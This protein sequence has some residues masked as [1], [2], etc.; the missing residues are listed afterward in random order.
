MD[1]PGG[2]GSDSDARNNDLF[3]TADTDQSAAHAPAGNVSHQA[4]IRPQ[5]F[6]GTPHFAF[7]RADGVL[8]QRTSATLQHAAPANRHVPDRCSGGAIQIT[9]VQQRL[10]AFPL[11]PLKAARKLRQ[12]VRC[13]SRPAQNG[14]L[15]QVQLGV[16][17]HPECTGEE[18]AARYPDTAAGRAVIQRALQGGGVVPDPVSLGAVRRIRHRQ[19]RLLLPGA[20]DLLP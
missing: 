10:V 1:I 11:N 6:I 20:N 9:D 12:I 3:R 7:F 2:S 19:R 15:F 8:K 5:R 17:M 4:G 16:R 14:A 18:N 13:P